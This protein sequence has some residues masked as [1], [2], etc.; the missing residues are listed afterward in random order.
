MGVGFAARSDHAAM[1][2]ANEA[3]RRRW[4]IDCHSACDSQALL[5]VDADLVRVRVMVMV[6]VRVM[7]RC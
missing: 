5:I 1:A 3:G 4:S 2:P 6:R 7:V